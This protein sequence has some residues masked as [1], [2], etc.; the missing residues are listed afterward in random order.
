MNFLL[1]LGALLDDD[2]LV[3]SLLSFSGERIFCNSIYENEKGVENV[4]IILG[5]KPGV[6]NLSTLGL[7]YI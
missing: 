1:K 5:S 3:I 7:L 4:Q 6:T 2:T